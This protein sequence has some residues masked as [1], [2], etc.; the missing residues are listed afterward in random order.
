MSSA[1]SKGHLEELRAEHERAMKLL[2]RAVGRR[3]PIGSA[4]W[5]K[6]GKGEMLARV[7]SAPCE[8]TDP[9]RLGVISAKGREVHFCDYRDCR[10]I[11]EVTA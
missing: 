10:L 7:S 4:V 9:T 5:V 3:F 1:R 11:A 8:W 2:A 6:W